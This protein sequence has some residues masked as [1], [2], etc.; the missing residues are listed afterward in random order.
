MPVP[1]HWHNEPML[2]LTILAAVWLYA[3]MSGPLR[4]RLAPGTPY[5]WLRAVAFYCGIASGYLAV[6]SPIDQLGEDF[7][8]SVHMV[9]HMI[10]IYITPPL[11]LWGM[12]HWMVDAVLR[13]KAVNIC[14]KP[15]LNPVFGLLCFNF[16]MVFW[17]VPELY[18]AALRSRL[19]HV[20][21]HWTM[22]VPAVFMWWPIL[23]QSR[24]IPSIS[25]GG[26]IIYV[27]LL[28]IAQF[29][30]FAFLTFSGEVLYPTYE[31][32]P[33]I[34]DIDPL[35]DQI[36]GGVIMKIGNMIFSLSVI[37]TSFYYW[38]MADQSEEAQ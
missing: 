14:L 22:F 10:L 37:A 26:R 13:H 21:E 8:F 18:E 17:H 23:S 32:A 38:Y 3:L 1:L 6:G 35:E 2:L 7:L 4:Q 20:I 27:F 28:M 30:V 11:L 31:F 15:I 29:P 5:P 12:P 24:V 25:Y 16:F 36:L 19:I 33:R 34:I 9:Q